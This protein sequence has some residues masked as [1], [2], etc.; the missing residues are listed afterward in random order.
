MRLFSPAPRLPRWAASSPTEAPPAP[1][2]L[3]L[4]TQRRRENGRALGFLSAASTLGATAGLL[5]ARA[6]SS[7]RT[8]AFSRAA[9]GVHL[10]VLGT[11][12]AGR[13]AA[14]AQPLPRLGL[15]TTLRRSRVLQRV[16]GVGL[17]LDVATAAVGTL[18]LGR[19]G[20]S[21][22]REGAGASLLLHGAALLLF[23]A[24]VFRRNARYHRQVTKFGRT[25]SGKV[26][27]MPPAWQ[28]SRPGGEA[29]PRGAV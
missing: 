26:L 13:R 8:R 27:R 16:L 1:T 14:R 15:R 2:L 5:G 10:F 4:N 19:R 11:A 29:R 17:G 28:V 3:A 21:A 25:A 7:V 22:W 12:L 18:L 6:T 23:D 20:R 9:V 24:W